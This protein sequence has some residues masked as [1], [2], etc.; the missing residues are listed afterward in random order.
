MI[1]NSNK[2]VSHELIM[3]VTK[4]LSQFM[5]VVR[6]KFKID[7]I[8]QY[9]L[10]YK[11][12]DQWEL[13]PL[14]SSFIDLDISVDVNLILNLLDKPIQATLLEK[15]ET[16]ENVESILILNYLLFDKKKRWVVFDGCSLQVYKS[17]QDY[18]E[19][20]IPETYQLSEYSFIYDDKKLTMDIMSLKSRKDLHQI[21]F[22]SEDESAVWVENLVK[23]NEFP[24]SLGGQQSQNSYFGAPL[25]NALVDG[26]SIPYIVEHCIEYI[27]RCALNVEG[28]FRLSGS[29]VQIDKYREQFNSGIMVDLSNEIDPH[30]VSGL[31]KLYFREMPEPLLTYDLYD[32]F[33][34]AQNEKDEAKRIRYLRHLVNSL[35]KGNLETLKYLM[36]FL[37][38]VE[39]HSDVNKMAI[40]NLA[41]VFAPNLL[42]P[43]E[44]NMLQ[45][46]QDSPLVNGII[47]TFIQDFNAIFSEQEP[48]EVAPVMAQTLYDYVAQCDNELS[49][50]KDDII[51]VHQQG[52]KGWWYGELNGKFGLFPGS[53]VKLLPQGLTKK[54]QFMQEMQTVKNNIEEEK[55][56][57]EELEKTKVSLLKEMEELK[58]LK[59]EALN[60][61]NQLKKETLSILS[62]SNDFS[63]FQSNLIGLSDQFEVY[64]KTKSAMLSSQK[65][66]LEELNS[67]KKTLSSEPSFRKHK[68]KL[69]PLIE[70]LFSQYDNENKTIEDVERQKNQV[71]DDMNEL[72]LLL[73]IN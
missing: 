56:L 65:S 18:E 38:R 49:I 47:C 14:E 64:N 71:R 11:K 45:I 10:Y 41:T 24:Q 23:N 63:S 37:G 3:N 13:I 20:N 39:K 6:R 67:F 15:A 19:K 36:E 34:A 21:K 7:T 35:K 16:K 51:R 72:K 61:T 25:E 9:G 43:R 69:L 50:K 12:G 33:I 17:Q 53:Y 73:N 62:S 26:R 30:T 4:P 59:E 22:N 42:K 60:E 32:S 27:D 66:L 54:Q 8:E 40:H 31:L 28:I 48:A 52:T 58:A 2:V 46:V 70:S 68:D 1:M 5:N 55:K 29:Q 57:I 44:G